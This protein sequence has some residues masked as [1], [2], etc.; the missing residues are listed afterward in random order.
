MYRYKYLKYKTKYENLKKLYGAG[1]DEELDREDIDPDQNFIDQSN[2]LD[3]STFMTD[4][5]KI[6]MSEKSTVFIGVDKDLKGAIVN[7]NDMKKGS[8]KIY[9]IDDFDNFTNK[10]GKISNGKCR[11][12]WNKVKNVYNG[13]YVNKGIDER[14]T[15]CVIGEEIGESWLIED[16]WDAGEDQGVE[17]IK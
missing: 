10:Y 9:S 17:W 5:D 8:L 12:D 3:D 2:R 6:T 15:E 14:A 1:L 16:Y 13:I 4:E 11:I 7:V